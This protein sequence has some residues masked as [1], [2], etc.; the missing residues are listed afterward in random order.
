M[1]DIILC[2]CVY[3]SR[4]LHLLTWLLHDV[5]K[6][7]GARPSCER[8]PKLHLVVNLHC[9]EYELEFEITMICTLRFD[10]L[11]AHCISGASGCLL[12]YMAGFAS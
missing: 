1:N 9:S 11:R 4:A 6:C 8:S 10:V 7:D 5:V 12:A 2:W 3:T